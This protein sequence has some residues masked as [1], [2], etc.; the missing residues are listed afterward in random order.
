[1][2]K[3]I[4]F[5][6]ILIFTGFS[7]G[8]DIELIT[9]SSSNS[10]SPDL[11]TKGGA[12]LDWE[13]SNALIGTLTQSI[14]DPTFDF[15]ANNGSPIDITISSA[16]GL[17]NLRN[18]NF[19][20]DKEISSIDVTSATGLRNLNLRF[21]QI[22]TL[23]LSQ[24]PELAILN[25]R[26][27]LN[28]TS[29]DLSNNPL[30]T[31]LRADFTGLTDLD[32]SNNPLLNLVVV[33][34]SQLSSAA[35][36]QILIDLDNNGLSNGQLEI[37]RN[38]GGLTPASIGAYNNLI[39]K[40]WTIDVGLPNLQTFALTTVSNST[41]WTPQQVV[42][43]GNI[44]SWEASNPLIGTITQNV[45]VP[46]F[47]FGANNGSPIN[48]TVT[49]NDGFNGLTVLNFG[50]DKNITSIDVSNANAISILNARFNQIGALD[51]SQNPILTSLVIRGNPLTSIDLSNNPLLATLRA[52]ATGLTT[53]DLSNNP[54][55]TFVSLFGS[56]LPSAVLDQIVIDLDNHGLSNGLLELRNN[57]GSLT[58]ASL[59]SYNNLISRGWTIDVAAPIVP[60]TE[61]ITIITNST[62]PTWTTQGITNSGEV[63]TW[64]ATNPVIGTITQVG[65]VPSFDFSG[66]DG[67][68][69]TVTITSTDGFDGLTLLNFGQTT[70]EITSI[71][72]TNAEAL[73]SFNSSFNNLTTLDVSQNNL[74]TLL[75]LSRNPNLSSLDI[76]NN[77]QLATLITDGSQLT[78]LDI[79]NNTLLTRVSTHAS[80]LPSAVLDQIVIDLDNHGLSNGLLE[81]RNNAGSLTAASLASYN[82]LISRG[83][84]ID[85]AAPIVPTTEVITII[86]NSTSPTWTTQ[87]I[88]NS[89]EVLTWEATNPVIGTITQVGNVPSF[90]F[91][92]NDGSPI[93]V[94]I[95]STDGFDGLT[96]LNFGQTTREITSIDLTNAEALVSFNSSFN[97]LTTLDVSQNNLLT[98]LNLSRNPNLSS[99]DIT[100]NTQLATLITDGSQLTDLNIS[101]NTLLTRVSAHASDLPSAVLDQIVI[102]LDNHGLSNGLLE[103]RNNAG[104]LTSASFTAYN[105]LI[106]K[107]WAIDVAA[108]GQPGSQIQVSGNN[109]V[110]INSGS[111]DL[112]SGTNF[113]ETLLGSPIV[114]TFTLTNIG[115]QDLVLSGPLFSTNPAAF[116]VSQQPA[117]LNIPVGGTETFQVTFNPLSLGSFT[118]SVLI[119]SNDPSDP[120]FVMNIAGQAVQVLS[121]QIM[122]SQYYQGFGPNDNWVE[123][124]NI[125]DETIPAGAFYLAL[126][127][128]AVA[129]VGVIETSNPTASELIPEL[130]PGDAILFR[131]GSAILPS[132]GNLGSAPQIST[133]VCTFTG[134][135]VILISS[136]NGTN[137]YND[138]VEIIGNISNNSN[139]PPASWG[140]NRCFIKGGCSSEEAHRTFSILDWSNLILEE[141]DNASPLTN[142][143]LGTQVVGPTSTIDGVNWTNLEPDPSRTAIITGSFAAAGETFFACN[144]II[145]AGANVVYDSNG[146]TNNSIVLDGDLIVNGSLVIGDTESLVTR[147]SNVEL[148]IITKIENSQPLNSIFEATYWSSPVADQQLNTVFAGVDPNRIFDYRPDDPNPKYENTIYDDYKFWWIAS[149][150]MDEAK[151]YSVDGSSTG[152]QTISFTGVP[153]NGS[154]SPNVYFSGVVDTGTDNNNFNLL[155]NPY[156]TAIDIAKFIG[157][158][159]AIN[160][161][162]LW[163]KDKSPDG[164]EFDPA[165]Y[166]FYTSAGPSEPTLT[167]NIGSGQGF[168]ARTVTPGAVTFNNDMKLISQNDQFYKSEVKK[169]AVQKSEANRIWLELSDGKLRS[170]ILVG[171]F[172][173]A[174]DGLDFRYDAM[175]GLGKNDL[176]LYSNLDNAKFVIQALGSFNTD[177]AVNLGFDLKESKNLSLKISGFEGV[178]R[179]TDVYLVDHV[180]NKTHNLKDGVYKFNQIEVGEFPNRFTLQFSK[181]ALAVDEILKTSNFVLS[182]SGTGFRIDASKAVKEVK[183]F[184]V[185]GRNIEVKRPNLQSFYLDVPQAQTGAVLIFE[186][187]LENGSILNKKAI[188]L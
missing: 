158:N 117:N 179:D 88:T 23:D 59:A 67:S 40:G 90:D 4:L 65:N 78:D 164:N 34:S 71:D 54:L 156:P 154:I 20:I 151:G 162:A 6:I 101:N 95:T 81:L 31:T 33:R 11:V 155:G 85:V 106:A 29:L 102:D 38:A 42:N 134:N 165:G 61:V 56:N 14:D 176:R 77:T 113:G 115:D 171:F 149:G 170:N 63:L 180:L 161:I 152:V 2:I 25:V 66:N 26:Q 118:G 72:L 18:L 111:A 91:S 97:N 10:W 159:G 133:P 89:G 13:A 127:N 130:A 178:F 96:L 92:G 144:L 172:D 73:V 52:D 3:K 53:L 182:N 24:N 181:N 94:T 30:L 141:V 22:S 69:I 99:L 47:N 125:S 44:F 128:D 122:I 84:T 82:N 74:L 143:A 76:T 12:V 108:P 142:L 35:L 43:S 146:L 57:A 41:S 177:K 184:D 137:S 48:I 136:S 185:L 104:E 1:M 21:N 27:N 153:F 163:A 173:E 70:R 93:T 139:N 168:M 148:G 75:N 150:A 62:S 9:T 110:I 114:N 138:R 135:D 188:K 45:D 129:R 51:V 103:L 147:S 83:W 105:N 28:L 186:V 157:D 87:G 131:N 120:F 132:A 5:L 166:I 107:G 60:T 174:T 17:G 68:P 37:R 183:V 187:K 36:D 126:F 123:V 19:G 55:L 49:S 98:L 16:D 121:N 145:E 50:L 169:G 124:I 79:S 140:D 7:Y 15:S 8:Q 175:G 32:L 64:E 112:A 80:D 46:T 39:G 86:T 109:I 160:E 100:N 119:S 58:A 167:N 116:Q